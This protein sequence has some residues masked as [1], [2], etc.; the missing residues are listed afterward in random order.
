M[1]IKATGWGSF[2]Q[3]RS[4]K[5]FSSQSPL[6]CCFLDQ[7]EWRL[8]VQKC[9]LLKSRK[10][11]LFICIWWWW[12]WRWQQLVL[13]LEV[14]GKKE[15]LERHPETR[16]KHAIR[17][18]KGRSRL[19]RAGMFWRRVTF[20]SVCTVLM[21]LQYCKVLECGIVWERGIL[22]FVCIFWLGKTFI[23]QAVLIYKFLSKYSFQLKSLRVKDANCE[24]P[25]PYQGL[26]VLTQRNFFVPV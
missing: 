16:N 17:K 12:W 18:K 8:A 24:G 7:P 3:P 20:Y 10:F 21:Y 26:L 14:N 19:C 15:V 4:R 11:D 13:F 1:L 2:F 23:Y 6:L 25:S 9:L 22:A 5:G